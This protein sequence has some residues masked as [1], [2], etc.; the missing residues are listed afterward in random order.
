MGGPEF[1]D[2]YKVPAF[3]YKVWRTIT[4][5]DSYK[6]PTFHISYRGSQVIDSYKVPSICI[7]YGGP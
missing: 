1:I 2:R 3:H 5:I 4:V 7:R 6:I